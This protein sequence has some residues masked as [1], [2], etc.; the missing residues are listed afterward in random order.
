MTLEE[1]LA[2]VLRGHGLKS[3]TIVAHERADGST[4]F[5]AY[6]HAVEGCGTG[7]CVG[8]DTHTVAA[9]TRSAIGDLA[10]IRARSVRVTIDA[11]LPE[12]LA[13]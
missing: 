12:G 4:W 13:A 8:G 7:S 10:A 5:N 2:A 11:S 1:Q 9:A 3:L 6:A